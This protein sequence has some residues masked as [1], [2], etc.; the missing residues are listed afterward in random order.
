MAHVILRCTLASNKAASNPH[1]DPHIDAIDWGRKR[2]ERRRVVAEGQ[3]RGV[4]R[5]RP[6]GVIA[7]KMPTPANL[8]SS[9]KG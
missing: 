1:A 8:G 9:E 6:S 7:A 5:R 4:A 2:T 3:L